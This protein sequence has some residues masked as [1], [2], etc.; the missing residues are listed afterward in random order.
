MSRKLFCAL[1]GEVV[2]EYAVEIDQ[3]FLY[4]YH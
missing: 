2:G 3:H 1:M 4:F